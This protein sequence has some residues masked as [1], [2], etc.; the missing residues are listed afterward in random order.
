MNFAKLTSNAQLYSYLCDLAEEMRR[1]GVLDAADVL[2]R[3]SKFISGSP[4]EF[5]RESQITLKDVRSIY[6]S[7]LKPFK[8]SEISSVIEQIESAFRGVGGA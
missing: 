1:C 6:A 7:K 4:S 5:L 3:A 8:I 2:L